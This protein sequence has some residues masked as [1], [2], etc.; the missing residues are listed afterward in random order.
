M[1]ILE[2]IIPIG[3]IIFALFILNTVF[4]AIIY[5]TQRKVKAVSGWPDTSGTVVASQI[6][7]RSDS[8]GSTQYPAVLYSYTV[9]GQS[10]SSTRIAPGVE[11]GGSGAG[12]VVARYPVNSQVT[13]YYNPQNPS[14]AVLEKKA[15]SQIL[16]W[17]LLILFDCILCGVIPFF[18]RGFA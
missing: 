6:E 17:G 9:M 5:F 15:G 2:S 16:F 12:K 7:W 11:M 1:E 3:I 18:L 4:L 14:D 13:V 8:E 10:Y